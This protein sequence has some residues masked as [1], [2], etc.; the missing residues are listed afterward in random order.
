MKQLQE[1]G[2][3]HYESKAF[4]ALLRDKLSAKQLSKKAGIPY[5]KIYFVINSLIKRG[6]AAET[7][8]RP[9]QYYMIDPSTAISTLIEQKERNNNKLFSEL[10]ALAILSE[11]SKSSQSKF[12]ELGT[13]QE[14]NRTIQL[15]TFTE[16]QKEVCQIINIHHKPYINRAIKL[17]WEKEIEKA[18]KRG[19]TFRS[20]YP[21]Q[22]E[23][24]DLLKK[25]PK[26]K[27]HV[28]RM[29]TNFTRCDIIDKKKTC[30]KLMHSDAFCFGGIVFLE[31]ETFSK[32]LQNI[33]ETFWNEA[34]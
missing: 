4:E 14:D 33:F 21:I 29:D 9:K 16:A 8:T 24:P 25:L 2:L 34:K 18:I 3:S 1:L 30:I 32:N 27:F 22:A 20:I 19:V 5:G 13:T 23:L 6:F 15:R 7:Q 11:K 31:D 26:D 17:T 28:K 12:F 10:R